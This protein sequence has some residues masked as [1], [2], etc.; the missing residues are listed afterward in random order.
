M[1]KALLLR[2]GLLA[3]ALLS[4]LAVF[5]DPG[6]GWWF[7]VSSALVSVGVGS[8]V[9]EFGAQRGIG[10]AGEFGKLFAGLLGWWLLVTASIGLSALGLLS[11]W[12]AGGL[13]LLGAVVAVHYWWGHRGP[14]ARLRLS[15]RSPL[16]LTLGLALLGPYLVRTLVPD[17][18]WDGALYH[19]PMASIFASDGLW[20]AGLLP[21]ALYRP[22]V[23]QAGYAWFL[24]LEQ[25]GALIP[26][27]T[28]AVAATAYG[29]F[30]IG[31][32][33]WNRRVGAWAAA[34]FL[35][36]CVVFEY[37]VDVRVEPFLV[38]FF[39]VSVAAAMAWLRDR[40]LLQVMICA[41]GAGLLAGTKYN[42]LAYAAFVLGP[43]CI[44]CWVVRGLRPAQRLRASLLALAM[45]VLPSSIFYAR[46]QV[47]FGNAMHPYQSATKALSKTNE[48]MFGKNFSLVPEAM[49]PPKFQIEFLLAKKRAAGH[50]NPDRRSKYL[51]LFNAIRNPMA[52]NSK[53]FHW[54]SPWLLLFLLIP[55]FARDRWSL[56]LFGYG[57]GTYLLT[58]GLLATKGDFP[59]R[60][61]AP[62]VPLLAIGAGVC[63]GRLRGE[64]LI[65][66]L[67]L[68]V[69]T[70]LA[71]GSY[72]Q[73]HFLSYL[74]PARY[75]CDEESE[76]EYQARV[77][78]NGTIVNPD[79]TIRFANTGIPRLM[80]WLQLRLDAGV[81]KPSDRIFAVAEAKT[82]RLQIDCRPSNGSS[83]RNFLNRLK[84][85]DWSYRQLRDK[86]WDEGFRYLL[87]NKG[88]MHWENAYSAVTPEIL[89]AAAH[90]LDAFIIQ[91]CQAGKLEMFDSGF[92]LV[93]L[94]PK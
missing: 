59:V 79:G 4:V 75:L 46:N 8:R 57:L 28:I 35:S 43:A 89:T 29:S 17:A 14:G 76:L 67:A 26:L 7:A 74:Q 91:Q 70:P 6:R 11:A 3:Y 24:A 80:N 54:L 12:T 66:I 34:V 18:D 47:L 36:S 16:Y 44:A 88:W 52:H 62:L 56:G 49:R 10:Q 22:G 69:A 42:G 31:T 50:G 25:P 63:L 48:E 15:W 9:L 71:Y 94:K 30:R 2:P 53:P 55:V 73:Y 60:Y 21:H 40:Q 37:A 61:L 78:L 93:P 64:F 58:V 33:F 86:L 72:H 92:F 39:L 51:V 38:L 81:V 27:N 20:V 84:R 45:F 23:A 41:M 90:N 85:A 13:G 87:V 65:I 83:G 82:N 19:L 32:A 5:T 77:G 68:G 1:L